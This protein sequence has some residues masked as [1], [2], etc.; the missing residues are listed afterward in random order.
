MAHNIIIT[1][2]SASIIFTAFEAW[3]TTRS[4]I[5]GKMLLPSCG[6]HVPSVGCR[7]THY[8]VRLHQNKHTTLHVAIPIPTIKSKDF[9][10]LHPNFPYCLHKH[11]HALH[12]P[13]SQPGQ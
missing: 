10:E 2:G 13:L 7:E 6:T 1:A 5:K 4:A 8:T 12:E 9:Q 3:W 11:V